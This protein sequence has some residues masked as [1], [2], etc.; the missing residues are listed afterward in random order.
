MFGVRSWRRFHPLHVVFIVAVLHGSVPRR[1]P[2]GHGGFLGVRPL[3]LYELALA[4]IKFCVGSLAG[5]I[6]SLL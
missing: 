3:L 5:I 4:A 2:D 1:L 6:G